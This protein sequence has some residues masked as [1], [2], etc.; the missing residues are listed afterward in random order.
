MWVCTCCQKRGLDLD[1]GLVLGIGEWLKPGVK[2]VAMHVA[3][4]GG[5]KRAKL[6]IEKVSLRFHMWPEPWIGNVIRCAA[7]GRDLDQSSRK[8]LKTII[9][10]PSV[11]RGISA[12]NERLVLL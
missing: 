9:F 6:E 5:Q 2:N 12:D 8:Q 1:I 10:F 3:R 11:N 4:A 7:R